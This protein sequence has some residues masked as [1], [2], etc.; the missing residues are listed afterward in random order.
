MSEPARKIPRSV[1]VVVHTPELLVLLLERA[2][3][4]GYWQS[5]TGSLAREDESHIAAAIREVREETGIDA[6]R[7]ALADWGIENRFEIY[8]EWRWKYPL[9]VT[10][11]VERV[12]GLTV[13]GPVAVTLAPAE[14]SRHLWLPWREAAEKCFSWSNRDA[15]LML[16]ERSG[17]GGALSA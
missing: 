1:L 5:V 14:H 7:H 16:P 13:P 9:G 2:P 10:H 8:R 15:I 11:N 3:W 6:T 4:P 12:F 17:S